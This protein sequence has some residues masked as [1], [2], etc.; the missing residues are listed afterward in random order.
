MK[1]LVVL[2]ALVA[3]CA[4]SATPVVPDD[5]SHYVEGESRYI[6]MPDGEGVPHLVDLQEPANQ[7]FLR[8]R[9]GANN[10]YWLYTRL[11]PTD[12][13]VIVH[14]DADTISSSNYV[15]SSPLMVLV[16]GWNG[17]G[18]STMNPTITDALLAVSDANVIVVDWSALASSL[19]STASAGVPSVGQYLGNF[20]VWLINTAGGDW[21]N[22][23]LVG[24]SL[25]AHAVAVAGRMAGGLATRVT[26]LDP[27]GPLWRGNDDAISSNAGTYVE[28]IHTDGGILGLFNPSGDADFYPNGGRNPQPGCLIS[29]CSHSRSH[30][31]FASTVR[32]NHLNGSLCD[33]INQAQINQCSGATFK[34]GNSDLSKQGNGIYGLTTGASWPF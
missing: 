2:S 18:N 22:V 16:H 8:N 5:N 20:L 17:D 19:Y 30:Q 4:G 31:L 12:P 6:W 28:C 32:Y 29:T 27:A 14:G 21:D 33:D 7:A 9:N 25:G 10:Q 1:L 24:H 11:N 15:A 34:M 26:G 13:Q 3:L 23:H